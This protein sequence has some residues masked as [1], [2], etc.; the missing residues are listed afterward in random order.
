MYEKLNL[1]DGLQ[2]W[3]HPSSINANVEAENGLY[4]YLE[5][6]RPLPS[7][8]LLGHEKARPLTCHALLGHE[9][10][11]PCSTTGPTLTQP[12]SFHVVTSNPP[13]PRTRPA[14]RLSEIACKQAGKRVDPPTANR[15]RRRA[16]FSF[17]ST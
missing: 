7:H 6:A 5:K 4:V 1:G 14:L 16:T 12:S 2:A 13:S 3:M 15:H 11:Q 9:K 17:S 10:A 8:A